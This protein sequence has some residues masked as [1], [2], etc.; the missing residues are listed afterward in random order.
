MEQVDVQATFLEGLACSIQESFKTDAH[1]RSTKARIEQ[2]I[3]K[4][5]Y[6]ELFATKN[7][8]LR[9]V[10]EITKN[11]MVVAKFS[12][13]KQPKR[14]V[15][16]Q[17]AALVDPI[18][19]SRKLEHTVH[20]IEKG[21]EVY[22][23]RGSVKVALKQVTMVSFRREKASNKP[24][25][26]I[27]KVLQP[28]PIVPSSVR[29]TKKHVICINFEYDIHGIEHSAIQNTS[30]VK[31][32]HTVIYVSDDDDDEDDKPRSTG[33]EAAKRSNGK[34]EAEP[35]KQSNVKKEAK[36]SNGKEEVE[37]PTNQ[38]NAKN[39]PVHC[40]IDIS[41]MEE[42]EARIL[43]GIGGNPRDN[44][45]FMTFWEYDYYKAHTKYLK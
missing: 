29:I 15:Q 21:N 41:S 2:P 20:Q 7:N 11:S 22:T 9:D 10:V 16:Q 1:R 5:L 8:P 42:D 18:Q 24:F 30:R 34:E 36:R 6:A 27:P 33:K 14:F 39:E 4:E 13:F 25:K 17:H 3:T 40:Q 19:L 32:E 38:S 35:P 31:K 37:P 26:V 44:L 12:L 28:P 23:M 43:K 45:V